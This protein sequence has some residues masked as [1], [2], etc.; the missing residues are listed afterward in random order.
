M[1]TRKIILCTG[2]NQ[3]LGFS[4]LKVAAERQPENIYILA[5]RNLERGREAAL[6]LKEAGVTA[7]VDVIQLDV[8]KDEEISAAAAYV[9]EKYGRLD[10]MYYTYIY[11]ERKIKAGT[12]KK[13]KRDADI[14]NPKL[15]SPHKQRRNP[16]STAN[17]LTLP[18]LIPILPA[19]LTK[20]PTRPLLHPVYVPRTPEHEPDLRSCGYGGVH[21]PLIQVIFF[22][23][24]FVIIRS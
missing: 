16:P 1:A 8:T 21:T 10:G 15:S 14:S 6:A 5:S 24:L 4:A 7:Q 11:T 23:F 3:G 18:I 20:N 12:K 13:R 19:I 2:A 22:F 9:G 17:P